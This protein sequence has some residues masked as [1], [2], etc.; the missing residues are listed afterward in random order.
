[1]MLLKQ[2]GRVILF[3]AFLLEAT[4]LPDNTTMIGIILKSS[5]RRFIMVC[6]CFNNSQHCLE[7]F[8]T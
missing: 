6:T 8:F 1:M 2:K 7:F 5:E 4:P 3:N